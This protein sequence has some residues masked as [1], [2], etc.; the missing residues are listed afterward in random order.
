MYGKLVHTEHRLETVSE[1]YFDSTNKIITEHKSLSNNRTR[2]YSY[3]LKQFIKTYKH[4]RIN[5]IFTKI[6]Q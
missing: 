3:S 2:V 6:D 4:S 1:Y 5:K